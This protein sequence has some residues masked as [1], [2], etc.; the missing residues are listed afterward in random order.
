MNVNEDFQ[1]VHVKSVTRGFSLV[2]ALHLPSVE[3]T[4]FLGCRHAFVGLATQGMG[5]S[6]LHN[7]LKDA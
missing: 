6:A 2:L 1:A 5:R 3:L 7:V 4:K